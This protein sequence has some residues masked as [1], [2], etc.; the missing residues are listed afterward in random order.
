MQIALG[1][2]RRASGDESGPARP[3]QV[4]GIIKGHLASYGAGSIGL[5]GLANEAK[6]A[7]GGGVLSPL[8]C[9]QSGPLF[10]PGARLRAA[11]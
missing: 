6:R 4:N 3:A 8:G 2:M 11:G 10:A 9:A 7:V 1:Q 5:A